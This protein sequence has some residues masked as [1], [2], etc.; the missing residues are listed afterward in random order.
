MEWVFV[1]IATVALW[2]LGSLARD[3]WY[4]LRED[5]DDVE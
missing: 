4:M 5:E 2:Q 1:L 3:L